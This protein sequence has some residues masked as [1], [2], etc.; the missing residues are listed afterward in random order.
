MCVWKSISVM[1]LRRADYCMCQQDQEVEVPSSHCCLKRQ[2]NINSDWYHPELRKNIFR[3]T[4][5]KVECFPCGWIQCR[6]YWRKTN[7]QAFWG[8]VKL[9]SVVLCSASTGQ[10]F[11]TSVTED[12][13]RHPMPQMELQGWQGVSST[14]A[15]PHYWQHSLPN[16]CMCGA[17]HM[18]I[19]RVSYQKTWTCG[20]RRDMTRDAAYRSNWRG[21]FGGQATMSWRK[22]LDHLESFM[23]VCSLMCCPLSAHP[24]RN[25]RQWKEMYAL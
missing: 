6:T 7:A 10:S 11:V 21:L 13:K 18:S 1:G 20:R 25:R 4:S 5:P 17:M 8:N 3:K 23:T 24:H 14:E 15:S 12:W 9:V 2:Q 22:E 16:M 19:I